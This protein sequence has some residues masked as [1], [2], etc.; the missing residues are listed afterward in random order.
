[1]DDYTLIS[2]AM[3]GL[4][5][6]LPAPFFLRVTGHGWHA[7]SFHALMFLQKSLDSKGMTYWPANSRCSK[8]NGIIENS[9]KF[10]SGLT[11]WLCNHENRKK[12]LLRQLQGKSGQDCITWKLNWFGFII[13]SHKI[14][15]NQR[16][17]ELIWCVASE[18]WV[19]VRCFR[20]WF[21]PAH[22]WFTSSSSVRLSVKT[23][24]PWQHMS[25]T[26]LSLSN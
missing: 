7:L 1:M 12:S 20:L 13:W 19:H 6:H 23:T 17:A 22:V 4:G 18:Y 9:I 15:T 26:V 11:T 14:S 2:I 8:A 24:V 10:S 5:W 3:V 21:Q 25:S 16:S